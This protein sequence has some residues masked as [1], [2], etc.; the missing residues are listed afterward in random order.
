MFWTAI[1]FLVGLV[2]II[3]GGDLFVDAASWMGD[4]TGIPKFVIGATVVSL[5]TTM[6]ELIVS[7]LAVFQGKTDMGVGNA[8]GSVTCNLGLILGLS[9]LV[10]PAVMKR[11]ELAEK[12]LLMMVAGAALWWATRDGVI[13]ALES[14][15]LL[16][17]LALFILLNLHSV[18]RSVSDVETKKGRKK[19]DRKD[20]VL[21]VLMFLF[22][23]AGIVVGAQL[24]V[25]K[26]T[27][28]ARFLGLSEK[29]IGLT[30]IALGTSLPELV[31]TLT[32]LAKKESSMSVGNIMGANLIDLTLILPLCSL[33]S[34]GL[35]VS[36]QTAALD[37]PILLLLMA[38]AVLPA[39]WKGKFYRWQGGAMMGVFAYYLYL[40]LAH[41]M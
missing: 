4:V 24:L 30:M 32:A 38:V 23:A 1:W 18:K 7:A 39:L 11:S 26:G 34:G 13:G 2:L 10:L 17:L 6:P 19:T 25:D 5:A 20:V 29:V 16:V 28:I 33:L 41:P 21:H 31:T 3:K 36:V 35:S 12:G 14:L 9:I 37:L 8:V 15:L 40:L 27:D 22:G